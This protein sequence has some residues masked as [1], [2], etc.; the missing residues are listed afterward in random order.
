MGGGLGIREKIGEIGEAIV[1]T[2]WLESKFGHQVLPLRLKI[3]NR[4]FL[5]AN[6]I[7][8]LLKVAIFQ[9]FVQMNP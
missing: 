3:L 9:V 6:L 5:V 7:D 4:H 1:I 2:V 8:S